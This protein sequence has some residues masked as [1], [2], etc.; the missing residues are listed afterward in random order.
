MRGFVLE[1]K[2]LAVIV[3]DKYVIN[4][5]KLLPLALTF[6]LAACNQSSRTNSIENSQEAIQELI[7][8]VLSWAD[9][10]NGIDLLPALTD[11][12]GRIY[13][14]LDLV[15]HAEN[16][17]KLKNTH[18]FASE[19]IDNYDQI[20]LAIDKGIRNKEYKEWLVEDLPTFRFANDYNPWWNGQEHFPLDL[21]SIE[22]ITLSDDTGEFYIRCAGPC[23]GME[24]FR[25]RFRAIKENNRWQISYL[26][27][28]DF[29][30][31]IKRDSE[32]Q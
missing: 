31:A 9:S 13:V 30:E 12:D 4:H 11:K 17:T 29:K 18:Y 14:R 28:F 5:S 2:M 24:N 32:N 1:I 16:L 22:T 27:G 8:D 15:K 19:L 3:I 26:E 10:E 6:A 25:T 23:N 20:I 7:H 21:I